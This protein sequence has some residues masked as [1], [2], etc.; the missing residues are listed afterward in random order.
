MLKIYLFD[1]DSVLL[2]PGGYRLALIS[3]INYFSQRMG[4]GDLAPTVEEIEAIEAAGITSEW[5]SAPIAV[6]ALA[7]QGQRPNYLELVKQVGAELGKGEYPAEAAYRVLAARGPLTGGVPVVGLNANWMSE[8]LLHSREI[9]RSPIQHVFQQYTL[10]DAFT[11]TYGLPR[12]VETHS[13]LLT[14]D[15]P[16]LNRPMPP[17]SV[18]YTARPNRPPRDVRPLPGYAPEAEIG[19]ELVGISHLPIIGFGSCQWLAEYLN[20]GVLAEHYVKPSPVQGLAAMGAALGGPESEAMLA[21]EA[22]VRGEWQRPLADLRAQRGQVT[23]FEDSARGI[24]GVREAAR[25]LGPNWTCVGAGIATAGPKREALLTV[26]DR[27][28]DS[29]DAALDGEIGYTARNPL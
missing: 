12:T 7:Q 16:T 17:Y 15:K 19:A 24:G 21:A 11:P 9:E 5:D 18:I 13:L 29:L 2:E 22:A 23:V 25:I 10:G 20:N 28:Y 6:V 26:A 4:L 27:V 3:T 1:M 8:A 14:H